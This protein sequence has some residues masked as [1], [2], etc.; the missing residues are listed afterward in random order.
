MIH[1]YLCKISILEK[2]S[3]GTKID[4]NQCDCEFLVSILAKESNRV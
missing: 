4:D 1:H 3:P 2:H